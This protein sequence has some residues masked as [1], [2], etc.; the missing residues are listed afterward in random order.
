MQRGF[1]KLITGAVLLFTFYFLN[2]YIGGAD[3]LSL[4]E[5]NVTAFFGFLPARIAGI[6]GCLVGIVIGI[7]MIYC[8]VSGIF[9]TATFNIY[10]PVY[11]DKTAGG[12]IVRGHESYPNINRV[13][14][15]R[16]SKLCSLSPEDGANLYI[17]SAKL[18]SLY[19]GYQN[20]PETQRTLSFIESKLCSM[21]N[22]RALNYLSNKL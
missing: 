22:E 2:D 7:G 1:K 8:F 12:T 10:L 11:E 15:Y 17:A 18:E 4:I 19:S 3:G 9:R 14:N 20:G 5:K 6:I 13:L 16:E 21:S